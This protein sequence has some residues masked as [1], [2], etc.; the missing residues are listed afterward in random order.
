[1]SAAR[2]ARAARN[3]AAWCDSVCRAHGVGGEFQRSAWLHRQRVPHLY[4]NVVTLTDGGDAEAQRAQIRQLSASLPPPW[5]VKDSFDSLHLSDL[6]FDVLF[7][8][9]WLWREPRAAD[10]GGRSGAE[11]RRVDDATHL[12]HWEAAW[13][14]DAGGTGARRFPPSLL[15]DRDI[16]FFAAYRN[17]SVIAGAIANRTADVVGVSNLFAPPA[18]LDGRW[19]ECVAAVAA[20]SPGL[21]I[22]GYECGADLAAAQAA[23]LAPLAE[24]CVWQRTA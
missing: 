10:R 1:M 18:E 19:A 16:A 22:T 11:W 12:L 24:L 8:A 20:W 23:G 7:R 13:A 6:G 2:V 17:D 9:S 14:A 5:S 21:A 3:N 4:P 15:D